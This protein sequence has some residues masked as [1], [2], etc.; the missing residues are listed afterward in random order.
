MWND[1]LT[2][3]ERTIFSGGFSQSLPRPCCGIDFISLKRSGDSGDLENHLPEPHSFLAF[4]LELSVED[5]A[6]IQPRMAGFGIHSPPSAGPMGGPRGVC[7][8]VKQATRLSRLLPDGLKRSWDKHHRHQD[9]AFG[10]LLAPFLSFLC[11]G[12]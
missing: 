2:H 9:Q 5:V 7:A 8:A 12:G 1:G 6:S 4:C 11:S 3:L 10:P